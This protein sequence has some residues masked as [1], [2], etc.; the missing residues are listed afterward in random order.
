[1]TDIT[2]TLPDD[3]AADLPA[4]AAANGLT[5]R[6]LAAVIV[7]ASVLDDEEYARRKAE[8]ERENAVAD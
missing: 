2:I 4:T 7:A 5:V 6:Q 3:I 1:M 8:V